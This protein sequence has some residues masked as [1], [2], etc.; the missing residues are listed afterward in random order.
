MRR[1]LHAAVAVA[2]ATSLFATGCSTHTNASAHPPKASAAT[3]QAGLRDTHEQLQGV[4]WTQ[5]A[6]ESW[7]LASSAYRLAASLLDAAIAEKTWTAALEQTAGY[8]SLP[9]AVVLDLD[10]TVLDN[11][12]YQ[13]QLVLDRTV[14]V[15]KTWED[16]VARKLATAVP[17]AVDFLNA[18]RN[19]GVAVLF[20]TNRRAS[21]QQSTIENLKALGIDASDET[22]LCVDEN[23]W[24]S[25]KTVRR[26]V[27]ARTH[28]ILLLI[29]DDMNDFVSTANL[30]PQARRD[31]AVK[32]GS[33]WGRTWIL[34]PNP[35][36][37]SWE[38]AL[39]QRG[40]PDSEVLQIKR[41]LVKASK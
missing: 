12:M 1:N 15:Q 30:S 26:S 6:A 33:R 4:L 21:E 10:E 40:T 22:V 36:Y 32:H 29:G 8:E 14:Y 23:G 3:P 7:V 5:T 2:L 39:Y 41:G 16:W 28:R 17:G 9:P 27:V 31:L 24:T 20:I 18:A 19:K 35:L 34:L 38:T 13:A 25:D 37:G 11:S